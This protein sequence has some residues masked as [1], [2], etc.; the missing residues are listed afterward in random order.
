MD[1]W[2]RKIEKKLEEFFREVSRVAGKSKREPNSV[3]ILYATKY[4]DV[5][6]F[7]IFVD[8]L[9]QKDRREL[10]IGES[11]VQ[12]AMV[13]FD[14]LEK[15]RPELGGWYKKVMI[16]NLQKNKINKALMVF[17]EIWGV[18]S[19]ELA[20]AIDRRANR[21]VPIFLEVNIS[22]EK[23]KHGIKIGE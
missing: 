2:R 21:V 9:R 12:D 18:D 5:E 19:V 20:K 8:I 17:D 15:K 14:Y 23:T 1:S 10:L 13:K 22:D 4:L 6:Q 3:S 16:G 11:R 7:E